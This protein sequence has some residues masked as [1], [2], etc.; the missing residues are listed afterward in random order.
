MLKKALKISL[1]ISIFF[2]VVLAG[3]AFLTKTTKE[4]I[5]KAETTVP[6]RVEYAKP[7][8]ITAESMYKKVAKKAEDEEA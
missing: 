4:N 1:I 3:A 6:D 7:E 2:A 8:I 5:K